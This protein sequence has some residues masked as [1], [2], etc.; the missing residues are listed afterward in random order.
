VLQRRGRISPAVPKHVL[1]L[2]AEDRVGKERGIIEAA[3]LN[4][5]L[6]VLS[7]LIL[8]QCKV[9]SPE[10]ISG[11]AIPAVPLPR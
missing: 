5:R 6:V 9:A 4:L 1:C 7:R 8:P 11:V 3:W 10:L 2:S